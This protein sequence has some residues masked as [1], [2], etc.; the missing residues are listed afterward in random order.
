ML[1]ARTRELM[2]ASG[3]PLWGR[4]LLQ[5]GFFALMF[6]FFVWTVLVLLVCYPLVLLASAARRE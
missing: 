4:L 2:A 5:A 1:P 6:L 3:M